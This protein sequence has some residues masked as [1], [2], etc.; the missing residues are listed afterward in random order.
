MDINA[1]ARK[2]SKKKRPE[3]LAGLEILLSDT[4]YMVIP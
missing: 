4:L 3:Y 2:E 1:P